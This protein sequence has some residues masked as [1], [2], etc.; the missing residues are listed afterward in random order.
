MTS[1]AA[2]EAYWG[3]KWLPSCELCAVKLGAPWRE[4][5]RGG[6]CEGCGMTLRSVWLREEDSK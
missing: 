3:Q 1:D 5:I 2:G 4:T 6:T